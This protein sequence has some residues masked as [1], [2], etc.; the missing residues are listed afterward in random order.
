M[1]TATDWLQPP[2][3][4]QLTWLALLALAG[5]DWL[6]RG[7]RDL[8]PGERRLAL[9]LALALAATLG[10]RFATDVPR[11]LHANLHGPA[12][13]GD[14]LRFPQP[15]EERAEYGCGHPTLLGLVAAALGRRWETVV[16]ADQVLGVATL[17]LAAWQAQR[18]L[19]EPA[20]ALWV[21]AFG[22][23]A[24]A[25]TLVAASEDAN[26]SAA[27]VA[28]LTALALDRYG[29]RRQ[30]ADLVLAVLAAGWMLWSRQAGILWLPV[31]AALPL[32]QHA[33]LRKDRR[34]L[35]ALAG[36]ALLLALRMAASW[37]HPGDN[38]TYAILVRMLQAPG[39]LWP[40]F[41]NHPMFSHEY[42]LFTAP[43]LLFGWVLLPQRAPVGR[44]L[45]WA[46]LALVAAT[47]PFGVPA[48]GSNLAFRW[49]AVLLALVPQAA[50]AIHLAARL[51]AWQR[52]V[53]GIAVALAPLLA[54][55]WGELHE[56]GPL[57]A[58]YLLLRA[59][60][61]KLP[62]GALL[63]VPDL[64]EP[65]PSWHLPRHLLP[66]E[67]QLIALD[68]R[69]PTD[70]PVYWVL[71]VACRGRSPLELRGSDSVADRTTAVLQSFRG[72]A[73][74]APRT[75]RSECQRWLARSH[76]VTPVQL[77]TPRDELPFVLY[78]GAPLQLAVMLRPAIDRG[79]TGR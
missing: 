3:P 18:W 30:A 53:L 63:A 22:A 54:P 51:R 44:P 78:G 9:W 70:R 43:L 11:F 2:L 75:L 4:L 74:V 16:R 13:L 32:W 5:L 42:A 8:E 7:W 79:G 76:P 31:A 23:L 20:A 65:A 6:R 10:L 73:P 38:L 27:A 61:P 17:G 50:A 1:T 68:E 37:Q 41:R 15:A 69:A 52:P 40:L 12:L 58:E 29:R 59:V 55:N 24:P 45:A 19:R 33:D 66:V 67:T 62:N 36:L 46:L 64:R 57:E 21:V 39:Q 77:V 48:P 26:V 25:L 47:L 71:G 35:A 49:P 72:E 28:W 34:L 60:L 56:Q 14:V